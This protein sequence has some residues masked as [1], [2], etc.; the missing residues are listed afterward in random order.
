MQDPEKKSLQLLI[1]PD[2]IVLSKTECK[3][4]QLEAVIKSLLKNAAKVLL[5]NHCGL[6]PVFRTVVTFQHFKKSNISQISAHYYDEFV[7][8]VTCMAY[9]TTQPTLYWCFSKCVSLRS[10][11]ATTRTRSF[12][13]KPKNYVGKC[14]ELPTRSRNV[15]QF[16]LEF[17]LESRQMSEK[18]ELRALQTPNEQSCS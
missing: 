12:V 7:F 15:H 13:F 11:L 9:K 10:C 3:R 17:L 6:Y 8:K 14:T 2:F 1:F 5:P 4:C 18:M 16:A